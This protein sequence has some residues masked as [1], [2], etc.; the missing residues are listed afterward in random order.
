MR[1]TN[2]RSRTRRFLLIALTLAG[3]NAPFL[4]VATTT[5]SAGVRECLPDPGTGQCVP[6]PTGA[7]P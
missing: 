2:L 1:L 4:A 5:A 3:V 7:C 6:C